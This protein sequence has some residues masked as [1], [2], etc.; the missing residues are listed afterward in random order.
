[1]SVY[2][3][4]SENPF[5]GML[6]CHMLADSLKELHE[7]ADK[8]GMRREWFQPKSTPHYDLC[9]IRRKLAVLHGAIE[10]DRSQTVEIIRAW[11][12]KSEGVK[13]ASL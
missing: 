11:R 9:Q 5:H 2:V 1:M 8:I 6:M 10:I 12:K 7:M 3:D 13:T 4:R